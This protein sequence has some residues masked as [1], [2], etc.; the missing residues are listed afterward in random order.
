MLSMRAS[1]GSKFAVLLICGLLNLVVQVKSQID[2]EDIEEGTPDWRYVITDIGDASLIF[3]AV[4]WLSLWLCPLFVCYRAK[5]K[6]KEKGSS[7]VKVSKIGDKKNKRGPTVSWKKES[8][9]GGEQSNVQTYV[10]DLQGQK[11]AKVAEQLG[12]K[13]DPNLQDLEKGEA[14]DMVD[15]G[16]FVG[17]DVDKMILPSEARMAKTDFKLTMKVKLAGTGKDLELL[18]KV[19]AAGTTGQH[20]NKRISLLGG[21]LS[22]RLENPGTAHEKPT[23]TKT[24]E[25]EKFAWQ[26]GKLHIVEMQY[27]FA[28]KKIEF[29]IDGKNYAVKATW[30]APPNNSETVVLEADS[31]DAEWITADEVIETRYNGQV[32]KPSGHARTSI[33]AM[34]NAEVQK[35]KSEDF[36]NKAAYQRGERVEYFSGTIA[37]WVNAQVVKL[38]RDVVTRELMYELSLANKA[39]RP[40]TQAKL[41]R[42]PLEPGEA[43]SVYL[44]NFGTWVPAVVARDQLDNVS[45]WGYRVHFQKDL[46]MAKRIGEGCPSFMVP[47][48]IIRRRFKPGDTVSMYKNE[49]WI[50][51]KVES[52]KE[53]SEEDMRAA[54]C[55]DEELLEEEG[56]ASPTKGEAAV[57]TAPL[58]APIAKVDAPGQGDSLFPSQPPTDSNASLPQ[59][60]PPPKKKAFIALWEMVKLQGQAEPVKS[61][62]VR[63]DP[64]LR[65]EAKVLGDE[66]KDNDL[67]F[68][69][70][71]KEQGV[72]LA[73]TATN[74]ITSRLHMAG[75]TLTSGATG[76]VRDAM[77][78]GGGDEGGD[79]GGGGG[80]DE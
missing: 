75:A 54:G 65:E 69:Q 67:R 41:L 4:W 34:T 62:F 58:D 2:I 57:F 52:V 25:G 71:A 13:Q 43:C 51:A 48:L 9:P 50:K 49:S 24:L 28:Q 10:W 76:A 61:V 46:D 40:G 33:A 16:L 39:T 63:L 22:F 60:P 30:P 23:P 42:A 6:R 26:P 73:S 11:L 8:G 17:D 18:T 44:T 14:K 21:K 70:S 35:Q 32:V 47:S 3:V 36:K 59:G 68:K 12:L 45:M 29:T 20:T 1:Q 53:P 79:E 31:E 77:G 37:S 56:G 72:N 74:A 5:G 55:P 38:E 66:K 7:A 80:G 78:G 19:Q 64:S 27:K 15:V